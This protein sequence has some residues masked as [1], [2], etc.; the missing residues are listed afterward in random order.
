LT[1]RVCAFTTSVVTTYKEYAYAE[2]QRSPEL[3]ASA[4]GYV[5]ST[6]NSKKVATRGI[7]RNPTIHSEKAMF[8]DCP[9]SCDTYEGHFSD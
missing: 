9:D 4:T 6:P 1:T 8:T 2:I 5:I 3:V 7:P